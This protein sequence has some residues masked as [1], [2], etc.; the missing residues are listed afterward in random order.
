MIFIV[1]H[2]ESVVQVNDKTRIDISKSFSTPGESPILGITITPEVLAAP[3]AVTEYL[4]WVYTTEGTKTIT[5]TYTTTLG[6]TIKTAEI[7]VVT[8][9]TDNLFSTDKDILAHESDL[10]N[11]LRVGRSSYIDKH[12]A[13]RDL[14]LDELAITEHFKSDGS[15]YTTAD[16]F[17]D[18]F[19]KWS[20]YNVLEL[21]FEELSNTADDI[22]N[23]KSLRY[24]DMKIKAKEMAL[25]ALDRALEGTTS[26]NGVPTPFSN[27]LTRR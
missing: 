10:Y 7:S 24:K 6:D 20:T 8:V 11:Y 13:I 16:T 23:K 19:K 3:I 18:D 4:D 27:E 1:I 21:I 15:E 17:T 9:A 5:V 14:I 25:L 22:F 26:P 12:R 2:N